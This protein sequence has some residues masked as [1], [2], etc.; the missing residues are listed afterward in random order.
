MA[1]GDFNRLVSAVVQR[2]VGSGGVQQRECGPKVAEAQEQ[3]SE[4]V[5]PDSWEELPIHKIQ[6]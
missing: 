2:L 6:I 1:D 4:T 5:V 3:P